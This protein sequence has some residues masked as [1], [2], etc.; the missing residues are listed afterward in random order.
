VFSFS[1]M[2]SIQMAWNNICML[3]PP[4]FLSSAYTFLLNSKVMSSCLLYMS[5]CVSATHTSRV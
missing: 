4:K 1:L 3:L 5:V 2:I